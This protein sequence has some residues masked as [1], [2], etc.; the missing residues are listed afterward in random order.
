MQSIIHFFKDLEGKNR[1][2]LSRHKILYALIGGAGI[3]LYWRGIWMTADILY[4]T[5]YESRFT[6]WG[7]LLEIV[8]S[9]PGTAVLGIIV[10]LMTGLLVQEF[11]GND[12]IISG[13]KRDKKVI[14]KTE[15]EILR[16]IAEEE[17]SKK[18]LEEIDTHL[19]EVD[20]RLLEVDNRLENIKSVN[21]CELEP[22][23]KNK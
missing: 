8:F 6:F 22:H 11:I 15:E 4:K 9:G 20:S 7:G 3:I 1:A 17:K 13:I 23:I 5:G 12:I 10:L 2:F 19:E 21:V 18:L 16:D 14:D